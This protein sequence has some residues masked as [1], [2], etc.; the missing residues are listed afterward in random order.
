MV[1]ASFTSVFLILLLMIM[2]LPFASEAQKS[3]KRKKQNKSVAN[4]TT[5][6]NARTTHGFFSLGDDPI[7]KSGRV[8]KPGATHPAG[9]ASLPCPDLKPDVRITSNRAFD[10]IVYQAKPDLTYEPPPDS[11]APT[12]VDAG[13]PPKPVLRP[14]YFVFD[15]DELTHEDME[16]IRNAASYVQHG[17]KIIIEGHTDSFGNDLYNE[18]LARRRAERIKSIM[19]KT[20]GI[21]EKAVTVV[22]YGETRPAVPNDSPENRRLNRRVEIKVIE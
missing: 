17:Y 12:T 9:G 15:E 6:R 18:Q 16:T 1:R 10:A 4:F 2:V 19:L 14:L 22:S 3:K 7:K 5:S 20:T 21:D 11:P 13:K 8:L